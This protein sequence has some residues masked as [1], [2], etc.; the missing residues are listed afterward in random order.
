MRE[1]KFH[2]YFAGSQNPDAERK[3]QDLNVDRLCSQ[4][5]DRPI[6]NQWIDARKRGAAK[7]NLFI[8]SGAY[9]AH[10]RGK[11]IDVDAYIKYV[12]DLDDEI[13]LV[14]QLDKIPGDYKKKKTQQQLEDAPRLSWENYLYMRERL[15]SPEKLLPI[16]HQGEEYRWL[17]NMLNA[18][19][20]GEPIGYIG[21]SPA[22]DMPL[23]AKDKFLDR[24]YTIIRK[25]SNPNVKTHIFGMTTLSI[26]EKY[27]VYSADSTTWIMQ[28][29][30]GSIVTKYGSIPV[31]EGI[32]HAS[33][34]LLK[35]PKAIQKDIQNYVESH[36]Y[37]LEGLSTSYKDRIDFNIM[38]FNE[39]CYNYE[40]KASTITRK[41][42][43]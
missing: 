22:N 6:I 9:S 25:S 28:G 4:L 42:L 17:E 36:G 14:A 35:L 39:W 10:T 13:A 21:L 27:P 2:L 31:S 19:F 43:F 3:L 37:N 8:D 40:L 11:E 38:Y 34:H 7:G 1:K 18:R 33:D 15:K 29:A 30:M 20:D 12:N 5:L 23:S 24:C 26:L 41:R 16:F 32:T